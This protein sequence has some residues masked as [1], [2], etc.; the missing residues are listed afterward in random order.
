MSQH[1]H[2]TI[3]YNVLVVDADQQTR[4]DIRDAL[5]GHRDLRVV[6]IAPDLGRACAIARRK[7]L[8][9]VVVGRVGSAMRPPQPLAALRRLAPYAR[10]VLFATDLPLDA[11]DSEP[12]DSE[13]AARDL[14]SL[15][16][17]VVDLAGIGPDVDLRDEPPQHATRA[18]ESLDGH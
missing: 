13:V 2:L 8:D 17:A 6:G 9:I 11:S 14:D 18:P 16:R 15:V 5:K 4:H 1:G 12:A 10:L 7:D 3:I